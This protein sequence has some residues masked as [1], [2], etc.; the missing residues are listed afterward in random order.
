[1]SISG[2]LGLPQ[3]MECTVAPTYKCRACGKITIQDSIKGNITVYCSSTEN[4]ITNAIL[5]ALMRAQA[6]TN[7]IQ[8]TAASPV[9]RYLEITHRCDAETIGICELQSVKI[10]KLNKIKP[11]LNETANP[12]LM[13]CRDDNLAK[14]R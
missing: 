5:R 4:D 3:D 9:Q 11:N 10:L 7:G 12:L 1:M 8:W 14:K 2:L 6:N 13:C